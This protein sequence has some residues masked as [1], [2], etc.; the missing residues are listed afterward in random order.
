MPY[1]PVLMKSHVGTDVLVDLG[2][3]AYVDY[4]SAGD[5]KPIVGIAVIYLKSQYMI[6]VQGTPKDIFISMQKMLAGAP[7]VS[8]TEING[9]PN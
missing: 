9:K 8:M 1:I 2:D 6:K 5:N 4:A 3:I 7:G